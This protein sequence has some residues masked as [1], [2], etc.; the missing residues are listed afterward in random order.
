MYE[1]RVR[2]GQEDGENGGRGGGA[3][4]GAASALLTAWPLV[5][6]RACAC[7]VYACFRLHRFFLEPVYTSGNVLNVYSIFGLVQRDK[8][9]S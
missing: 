5:F 3:D 2:R 6:V 4:G 1:C 8:V 7:F 9:L